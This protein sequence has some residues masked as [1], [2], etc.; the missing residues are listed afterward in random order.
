[1]NF[2]KSQTVKYVR[3]Y[4]GITAWDYLGKI[5]AGKS[6]THDHIFSQETNCDGFFQPPTMSRR[7]THSAKSVG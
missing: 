6:I 3:L 1:M 4:D 2:S 7:K 5:Q